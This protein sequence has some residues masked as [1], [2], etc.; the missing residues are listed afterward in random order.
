MALRRLTLTRGDTRTYTVTFK[1]ADGSP[2][3]IKNWAVFFTVKSNYSLPDTSASI[4]KI[5]TAFSDTTSGTSGAAVIPIVRAD[6]INL[7]IGEYDFDIKV[8]TAGTAAGTSAYTVMKGKLNLEYNVT[9][10]AGTAGSA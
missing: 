2:Y 5:I 4:Q 7:D 8:F 1:K 3:N 9:G 6:T 10:T